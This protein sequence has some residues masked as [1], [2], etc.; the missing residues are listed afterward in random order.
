[1][2]LPLVQGDI[3]AGNSVPITPREAA[4]GLLG[5]IS[6]TCW[7]FLLVPQLI[8]NYCNGNAEAISL[9]F[10]FVW[11]I[12]DITNL[13]GGAWA[14]LVPVIVAIAVYF[15]IADGVLIA[16]C[17]Y[18]KSRN[19]RRESLRRRRRSSTVTPDPTT[20]LLGR[21]FS[22][23][24]ERGPASRRRSITSQR[25]GRGSHGHPDDALAIIIEENEVGRSAW[26]KNF[27]SVLAICVIGMAGWTVA[28]QTGVWK[29]AAKERNGGVDM[30]AG[31]QV[32]GYISAVCYLGARLPQI[33]KNYHDKSCDG[34]SLLFFILSLM[35]NLTY[36]A[37]ILCHSTDKNYVVTNLPWLIGSLGT[38]VEDVVIFVQFRIYA[39]PSPQLTTAVS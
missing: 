34:L 35:G 39:E 12:G 31:A 26:V 2:S 16:Q 7:F 17:L 18:Y 37:G 30:A 32:L 36:G 14:G 19:A 29:P 4:S 20:P 24:L 33:Y 22:D 6:L 28:W 3:P 13:I 38:M 1:M 15:C 27:S 25:S 10:L 11:F 9:L 21:R 5:S 8:E 23:T